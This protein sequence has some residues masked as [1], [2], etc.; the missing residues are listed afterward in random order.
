MLNLE[1][2][3]HKKSL[4]NTGFD[5]TTGNT[6]GRILN[7]DGTSNVIKTG[8]PY[9][10]RISLFHTLINLALGYFLVFAMI[11]FVV[12]NIFFA[13]IYYLIGV[14]HIGIP[15]NIS[16]Q[17][18]FVNCF[19]FSAQTI[20][21][22]G[23]GNM[24]PDSIAANCVATFESVFGW[25]AF[26]VLTGLI[27]GRF[28][29]PKAYLQFS[30]N[31]LIGP[32]KEGKALMFRMAPYKNNTLTEAEVLINISFRI[33]EDN[34]VVNKF[35]PLQVELNKI[36]SLSLNWTVVHAI[37]QDSPLF[38]M[39]KEDYEINSTEIMVFVKAFDEHFSN[40]VQQRTSYNFDDI[41]H[42][43]KF[44]Q[45]FRQSDNK[46]ATILELDKIHDYT[47]M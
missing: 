5:N 4:N 32:Y 36:S 8:I 7:K 45:M 46:N 33:H 16:A 22:V 44:V 14:Q 29:K 6:S 34:K 15:T 37:N 1:D 2:L 20:T 39:C 11:C 13:S 30:K 31:A 23:Y 19:F 43:A 10:N 47:L 28:A 26:A 18:Q 35:L 17:E 9:F 12:A 40:T 42:G 27:Y 3:I 25:M 24:H 38:G 21:T 41:V